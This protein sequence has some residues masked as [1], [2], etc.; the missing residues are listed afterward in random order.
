MCDAEKGLIGIGG[1]PSEEQ[2]NAVKQAAERVMKTFA[3]NYA[4]AFKDIMVEQ[5]L[6]RK[7]EKDAE[8]ARL[9]KAQVTIS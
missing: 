7:A 9:A 6:E 4:A 3:K 2:L 1:G 8:A 5:A